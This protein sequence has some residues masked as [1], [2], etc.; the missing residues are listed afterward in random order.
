MNDEKAPG[1]P[2]A[3]VRCGSGWVTETQEP[4]VIL[5]LTFYEGDEKVE[6]EFTMDSQ[7]ARAVA[8]QLRQFADNADSY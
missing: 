7:M 6:R 4:R 5:W 2:L 1:S 3:A 8:D